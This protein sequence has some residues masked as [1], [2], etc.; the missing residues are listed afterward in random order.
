MSYE[1]PSST[2]SRTLDTRDNDCWRRMKER[3][4]KATRQ[5]QQPQLV[6]IPLLYVLFPLLFF[7]LPLVSW[8]LIFNSSGRCPDTQHDAHGSMCSRGLA[9]LAQMHVHILYT[10]YYIAYRSMYA[11]TCTSS[12]HTVNTASAYLRNATCN[13]PLQSIIIY[14]S[15][16]LHACVCNACAFVVT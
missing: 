4:T 11:Y 7:S 6:A 3:R 15:M 13:V 16:C 12:I 8:R 9:P 2:N 5:L 14:P 10:V 1:L